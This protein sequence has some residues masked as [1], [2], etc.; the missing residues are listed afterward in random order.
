MELYDAE[1]YEVAIGL[2]ARQATLTI[3]LEINPGMWTGHIAPLALRTMTDA[4]ITLAWI[5]RD[6]PERARQYILHGLGQEKLLIAH[7]EA[8]DRE[9]DEPKEQ[10]DEL[11]DIKRSWLSAQR[12]DFLTEVNVGSWSGLNV[13]KNG[14]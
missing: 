11:L 9:A 12:H 5:L 8:E 14:D 4:H 2:V 1:T 3:H 6:P 13:R 7:L 10:L